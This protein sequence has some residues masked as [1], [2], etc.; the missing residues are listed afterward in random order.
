[1]TLDQRIQ[2]IRIT[3]SQFETRIVTIRIKAWLYHF[4]TN[5]SLNYLN[6]L[7]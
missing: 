6:N 3:L 2:Q 7:L 5:D 4:S 1:M